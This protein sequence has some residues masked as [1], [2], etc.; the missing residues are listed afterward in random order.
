MKIRIPHTKTL[1]VGTLLASGGRTKTLPDSSNLPRPTQQQIQNYKDNHRTWINE[2]V[3]DSLRK[4]QKT[5]ALHGSKSLQLIIGPAY[6]R[7]PQDYDVFSEEERK[8][9]TQIE[10]QLDQ[11]AGC[12]IA[13]TRYE[14]IPKVSFG[15]D[16]PYTG[17]HLYI[18]ETPLIH[19]DTSVDYMNMPENLPTETHN[20]IR[21]Q[22]LDVSYQ[23]A[24][25]RIYRQPLKA[26]KA[27]QDMH[28]IREYYHRMGRQLPSHQTRQPY[29]P[30]LKLRL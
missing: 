21:H 27:S 9:A 1:N 24:S 25:T 7:K 12:D 17:K 15:P 8:R 4:H 11:K 26:S 30:L 28:A 13:R 14:Y 16:D 2:I 29:T 19:G 23:K 3:M 5:D 20:G 18:V 6:P 22:S 10:K